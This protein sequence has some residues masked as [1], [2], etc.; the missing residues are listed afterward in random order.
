MA[1]TQTAFYS[2]ANSAHFPGVVAL[3]NSLRLVGHEEPMVLVDAGLTEEQRERLAPHLRLVP[4]PQ[5]V[6]SVFLAP[7]G[8]IL[9][10]AEI[11][12]V[13]DAD[14]IVTRSL[15]ELLDDAQRG[16]LVAVTNDPPNDERFFPAWGNALSL[17]ELRRRPYVNAGQLVIPAAIGA[18]IYGPW[19]SGQAAI[20]LAVSRYGKRPPRY[21]RRLL[22][23]SATLDDPFYFADQDV[24]NAVLAAELEDDEIVILEHRL[25]PHPPFKGLELVDEAG[26]VCRFGDGVEPFLLHHIMGKPWLRATPANVYSRL[27][28]RLLLSADV[29]VRLEPHEL[30]L[31]LRGGPL[32]RA[33]RRRATAQAVIAREARRRL[34]RFGIRSRLAARRRKRDA[35]GA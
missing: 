14:I 17:G 12:V 24:L 13:L 30:P 7:Y 4:A 28:G 22:V 9:E 8:P 23:Q 19:T 3:L 5:G 26:L 34:A 21:F 31:R 29:A 25:A 6:P 32:A 35:T 20:G 1:I 27:L 15:S 10:P 33:D 18:R 2:A 11:A 16:R